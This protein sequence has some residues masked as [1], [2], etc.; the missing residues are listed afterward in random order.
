MQYEVTKV[1]I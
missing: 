1:C